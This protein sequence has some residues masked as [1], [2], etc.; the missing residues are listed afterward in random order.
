MIFILFFIA[1]I[2]CGYIELFYKYTKNLKSYT[3][4]PRD[5]YTIVLTYLQPCER[6][7]H[8]DLHTYATYQNA[9]EISQLDYLRKYKKNYQS[10]DAL[11][12][13]AIQRNQ[14]LV[15]QLFVT[16]FKVKIESDALNLVI[17]YGRSDILDYLVNQGYY[18]SVFG[19]NRSLFARRKNCSCFY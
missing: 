3:M 16:E 11:I 17:K 13:L 6:A 4:W 15:I 12:T 10:S 14:L 7:E 18:D 1:A 19:R 9:I 8:D 2:K 5:V